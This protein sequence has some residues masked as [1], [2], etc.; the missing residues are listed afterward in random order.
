MLIELSEQLDIGYTG[1]GNIKKITWTEEV[2]I[3]KVRDRTFLPQI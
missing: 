3:S 1:N 2:C